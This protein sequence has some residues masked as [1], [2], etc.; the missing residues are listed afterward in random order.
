MSEKKPVVKG[1]VD[2]NIFAVVG[3]AANAMRK[4]GQ[5]DKVDEMRKKVMA[6]DSYHAALSAITEYVDFA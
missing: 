6:S 1:R 3:A 2:G 5:A 4:A